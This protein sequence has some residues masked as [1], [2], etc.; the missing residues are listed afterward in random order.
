MHLAPR[1]EK[2]KKA[3]TFSNGLRLTNS[4]AQQVG[5][6][7]FVRLASVVIEEFGHRE[8]YGPLFISTLE[9]F[10]NAASVT[11]LNSSYICDQEPDLVESYV[12][13]LDA[14]LISLLES[15]THMSGGGFGGVAVQVISNSG[16]GLVSNVVYALLGTSAMSRV[17]KS[18]TILQQLAAMSR[19]ETYVDIAQQKQPS[20]CSASNYFNG[21][22]D[23]GRGYGYLNLDLS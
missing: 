22:S 13:L 6:R 10:T 5:L 9:R 15:M 23:E 2:P 1:P 16:E 8:E 7:A 18:A 20:F 14:A 3:R 17:H 11:A 12:G 21:A 4:K 19:L